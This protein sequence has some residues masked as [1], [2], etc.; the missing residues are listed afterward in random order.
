MS[1][2]F[3]GAAKAL[4]YWRRS[5][6]GG[7]L[8]DLR[9]RR[10]T[11]VAQ[12]ENRAS[13]VSTSLV[14]LSSRNSLEHRIVERSA[15]CSALHLRGSIGSRCGSLCGEES[16][17]RL[18]SAWLLLRIVLRA[19]ALRPLIIFGRPGAGKTTIADALLSHP[20]AVRKDAYGIDLDVCVPHSV[21]RQEL[22]SVA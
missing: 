21:Q 20:D 8:F 9:G 2:S 1:F 10:G 14:K 12:S 3:G 6:G 19:S 18:S 17:S 11:R 4:A 5:G 16:M 15:V 22:F 13:N 7:V